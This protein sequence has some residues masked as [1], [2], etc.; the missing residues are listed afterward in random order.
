LPPRAIAG[1]ASTAETLE[2][3]NPGPG[4]VDL[5]GKWQ[6]KTGDNPAWAAP[7]F[8]DSGWERIGVDR[9]WGAQGHPNYRGFAW[10]R[11]HIA[12]TTPAEAQAQL[13][14][15]M[16]PVDNAYEVYWNG[17]LVGACGRLPPFPS[18]YAYTP[19][20]TFQL[21]PPQ[22][23]V[24]AIRVWSM[25][26]EFGSK[27]DEGGLRQP[28]AIG[29]PG[30][31][32]Y[33][34]QSF[35]YAKVRAYRFLSGLHLLYLLVSALG[36]VAWLRNRSQ[37]L[38]LLTALYSLAVVVQS[39]VVFD[40][41]NAIP[42]RAQYALIALAFIFEDISLW[43]L[44]VNLLGFSN[45]PAVVRW[46]IALAVISG[47][48]NFADASLQLF[49]WTGSHAR[50]LLLLDVVFTMPNVLAEVFPAVLVALAVRRR[51]SLANW[52]VAI[53]AATSE[54]IVLWINV[55]A[56]GTI[57]THLDAGQELIAPLVVG[58]NSFN[59]QMISQTCFFVALLY[60]VYRYMVEQ[61]QRQR[62][63]EQ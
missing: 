51:L 30:A 21:G 57:Y 48:G 23:G 12:F 1:T 50:L 55:T 45:R 10:Y 20:R 6:F 11:R 19:P 40:L 8:D 35:D 38:L 22:P 25:P 42:F 36:F 4:T 5:G 28:P 9:P 62:A 60:A 3:P 14:L 39:M 34:V 46:A 24:L 53:F 61:G 29:E 44:L 63:L 41:F 37:R 54:I 47:L 17:R 59:V 7:G 2:L 32:A 33:Q 26:E 18:W 49:N 31:I 56:L 13:T 58:G 43:F 27:L 52:L 16:G 15:L